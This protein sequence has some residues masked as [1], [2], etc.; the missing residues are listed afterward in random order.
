MSVRAGSTLFDDEVLFEGAR[1]TL[2]FVLS[3]ETK[4]CAVPGEELWNTHARRADFLSRG[5]WHFKIWC[6]LIA[7]PFTKLNT[8]KSSASAP[9]GFAMRFAISIT[10]ITVVL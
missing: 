6:D 8:A 7:V 1:V 5:V 10:L 9:N 2:C 4:V 3:L